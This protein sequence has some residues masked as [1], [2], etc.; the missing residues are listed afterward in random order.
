M[1][2]RRPLLIEI[3]SEVHLAPGFMTQE[4]FFDLVPKLKDLGLGSIELTQMSAI[5]PMQ[6]QGQAVQLAPVV[7][8]RV[9]CWSNDRK[10]LIQLSP[11]IIILNHVGDYLGWSNFQQFFDASCKVAANVLGSLPVVALSLNT[12]DK[13][14]APSKDFAFDHYF[15]CRGA[16]IPEWFSGVRALCDLSIGKG[17]FPN[18]KFNRQVQIQVRNSG[19]NTTVQILSI[20]LDGLSGNENIADVMQR[21]HAESNASFEKL[22]TDKTRAIMGGPLQ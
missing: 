19:D 1:G 15:N 8:P 7:I 18:D 4:R 10:K 22:V 6:S 20:F 21:L 17:F 12:I 9:K 5:V 13:L 16:I 11:D 14:T 3:Y 2:Y